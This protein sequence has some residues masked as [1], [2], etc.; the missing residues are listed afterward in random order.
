MTLDRPLCDIDVGEELIAEF[1]RRDARRHTRIGPLLAVALGDAYGA[2]HE[3]V[4]EHRHL[5]DLTHFPRHPRLP[6]GGGRYTD[7]TQMS[8][9]IAEVFVAGMPW[10]KIGL[11]DRFF[12]VFKRDPRPGYSAAFYA[13]LQNAVTLEEFIAAIV[14]TS[15]KNGAAMRAPIIGLMSDIEDVASYAAEQATVTHNTPVARGAAIAAALLTHYFHHARGPKCDVGLWLDSLVP[16]YARDIG[17]SFHYSWGA[18]WTGEVSSLA[19]DAVHAAV[20]AVRRW[21]TL[22]D[23]LKACVDFGGDVDTVGAIA[24]PAASRS[25]EIRDDIPDALIEQLEDGPFGRRYLRALD[26]QLLARWPGARVR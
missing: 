12:E 22:G 7:D 5:N 3:Y 9:A 16:S 13:I 17:F 26:E 4:P 15:E 25:T 19:T 21:N 11:A 2:G 23:V 24:M 1:A 6:I 18:L 20:T 14:P 10:T 8:I